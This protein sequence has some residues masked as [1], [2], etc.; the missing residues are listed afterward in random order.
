MKT[1][2]SLL[3]LTAVLIAGPWW[4]SDLH[5]QPPAGFAVQ[6]AGGT[7]GEASSSAA[8]AG[9]LIASVQ[10]LAGGRT[11]VIV[12]DAATRTIA[13]YVVS[14]ETSGIELKSVRNIDADLRLKDFNGAKPTPDE[15]RAVVQP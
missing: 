15:V 7:V 6:S 13:T 8:A 9:N 4:L 1:R 11:Q 14:A 10:S 5:S 12:V 2:V 3:V